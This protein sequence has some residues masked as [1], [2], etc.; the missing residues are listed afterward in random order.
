MKAFNPDIHP[1]NKTVLMVEMTCEFGSKR[2][3]TPQKELVTRVTSNLKKAN[4]IKKNQ[5]PLDSLMVK[6][7]HCYPVYDLNYKKNIN[8]ILDYFE[9]ISNFYTIGRPGLFFYNNI[10]HSIDMGLTLAK[11]IAK[12]KS[13]KQWRRQI[14]K[15][16]TYKIVD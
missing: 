11:H 8:T 13:P 5:S 7:G 10:D 1:K 14:K 12:H 9:T 16:F 3:N 15:F 2:W 6:I 4:L